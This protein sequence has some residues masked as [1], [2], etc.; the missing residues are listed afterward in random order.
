MRS[1]VGILAGL[2]LCAVATA[3]EVAFKAEPLTAGS[4]IQLGIQSDLR[5]YGINDKASIR[6]TLEVFVLDVSDEALK[7][8]KIAYG[9]CDSSG[10]VPGFGSNRIP[11]DGKV[12]LAE[13]EGTRLKVTDATGSEVPE[14]ERLIV[15]HDLEYLGRPH[16]I[17]TMLN[18]QRLKL[19]DKLGQK[20]VLRQVLEER[21]ADYKIGK[22]K[23]ADAALIAL[24]EYNKEKTATFAF[25]VET[26]ECTTAYDSKLR[27]TGQLVVAVP[28]G[29]P[30]AIKLDGP[31]SAQISKESP[32]EDLRGRNL[33][34]L[35][36]FAVISQT[37]PGERERK[38][39]TGDDDWV[40]IYGRSGNR[41][42]GR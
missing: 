24:G 20:D 17:A 34:G 38:Q 23:S 31:I 9:A 19:G 22:V 39:Y 4:L 37:I 3:N 5:F 32:R 33:R 6:H 28:T 18:G 11:V 1:S 25:Q 42:I 15:E 26:G 21:L 8:V 30:V 27:L 36:T 10:T 29:R 14:D 41:R 13:R 12:Y 7:K 40:V 16:P 35:F 2:V